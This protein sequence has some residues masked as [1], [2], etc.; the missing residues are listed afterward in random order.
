MFEANVQ[1]DEVLNQVV[2]TCVS[3]TLFLFLYVY[4]TYFAFKFIFKNLID[5]K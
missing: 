5:V 3:I 4:L 1:N 2:G